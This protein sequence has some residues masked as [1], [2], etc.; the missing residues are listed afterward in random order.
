MYAFWSVLLMVKSCNSKSLF[1]RNTQHPG[2]QKT[3]LQSH[4][5][6]FL[7]FKSPVLMLKSYFW[8][9]N[10]QLSWS[11]HN[12]P[13]LNLYSVGLNHNSSC[14][15]HHSSWSNHNF[16]W[17]NQKG[18]STPHRLFRSSYPPSSCHPPRVQPGVISRGS[19]TAELSSQASELRRN[20]H[21][22]SCNRVE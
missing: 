3:L 16:P 4:P 11:N 22:Q 10:H 5:G 19:R 20:V 21:G 13:C 17:F 1:G 6:L 7:M 18:T 15:N 2:I 14:L 12:L 9:L 8:C